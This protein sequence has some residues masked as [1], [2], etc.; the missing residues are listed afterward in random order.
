[1]TADV[2][3]NVE[4]NIR[5]VILACSLVFRRADSGGR[6]WVDARIADASRLAR[7]VPAQGARA[8]REASVRISEALTKADS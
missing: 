3:F 1:M 5:T 8:A 7:A 2:Y 6:P 4:T